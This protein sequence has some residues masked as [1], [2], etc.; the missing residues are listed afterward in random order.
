MNERVII[1]SHLPIKPTNGPHNLWN[2]FE[3]VNIIEKYRNVV[4]FINGHDH[5]GNYLLENGIHHISV[6]GMLDTHKS[7]FGIMELFND[8]LILKGY[9]KQKT[10]RLSIN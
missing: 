4:A 10:L 9:G 2:D 3:I 5:G 6:F 1:F 7:S 8:S